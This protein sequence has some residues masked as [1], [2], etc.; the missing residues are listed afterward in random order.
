MPTDILLCAV[1]FALSLLTI[2]IARFNGDDS[3][4]LIP[5]LL[6]IAWTLLVALTYIAR[7]YEV[8]KHAANP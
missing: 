3:P 2:I 1:L 8:V 7:V 6:S 5:L 4:E